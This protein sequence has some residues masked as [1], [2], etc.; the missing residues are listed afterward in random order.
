VRRLR[1]VHRV[2]E[3]QTPLEHDILSLMQEED[4]GRPGVVERAA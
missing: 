3:G 2:M 4:D 1:S